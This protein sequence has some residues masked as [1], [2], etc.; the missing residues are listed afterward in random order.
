VKLIDVYPS[1][2][3][4]W[5]MDS[6]SLLVADGIANTKWRGYP[7]SNEP[8]LLSGNE[9]DVYSMNVTMWNTSYV[10]NVGHSI[11]IHV[12]SSNYPRFR[13]NR[14]N[15]QPISNIGAPALLAHTTIHYSEQYPSNLLLPVVD[16]NSQ[17]PPFNVE[18][19]VDQML[20]RHQSK[21][22][23]IKASPH[24]DTKPEDDLKS[25][26]ARKMQNII[27]NANGNAQ[28]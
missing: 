6:D 14:N 21:W 28:L 15:G 18:L 22:E 10:F 11:R 3:P 5:I 24:V 7:N 13:P 23:M 20:E 27:P 26:L 16:L 12:S 25:W 4:D 19:A 2:D 1:N 17:L 9:N 8:Q